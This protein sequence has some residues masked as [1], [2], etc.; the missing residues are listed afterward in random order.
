MLEY[1]NTV[2]SSYA[3]DVDRLAWLITWLVGFWFIAAEVMFFWLMFRYRRRPGVKSE[4]ITG[5]EPH[6]HRWLSWSHTSILVFDVV[7]L[8][9]AIG[10]WVLVKQ[11][12]PPAERTVRVMSQQWA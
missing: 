12:T 1:F 3:G 6:L 5:K 7:I 4:Y 9:G 10:V 11:F 2:A 8:I